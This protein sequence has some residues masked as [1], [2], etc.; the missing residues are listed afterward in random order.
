MEMRY[1]PLAV[2]LKD[3][4][5]C[6]CKCFL[7]RAQEKRTASAGIDRTGVLAGGRAYEEEGAEVQ[8]TLEGE[9]DGKGAL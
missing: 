6:K 4:N 7:V 8:E 2:G 3:A 1:P 9:G 5:K